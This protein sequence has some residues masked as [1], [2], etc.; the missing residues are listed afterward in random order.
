M[1]KIKYDVSKAEPGGTGLQPQPGIYLG[2]VSKV[3]DRRDQAGKNDLEVIIDVTKAMD[4][5]NKKFV[6]ARLWTYPNFGEAAD[7]KMREFTDAMG[8]KPK[9][10][11]DTDRLVGKTVGMVIVADSYQDQYKGRIGKLLHPD[12]LEEDEPDDVDED[13]DEDEDTEDEVDYSSMSL[14]DLRAAAEDEDIDHKGLSKKDLIAA[15]EGDDEDED[16]DDED[17]DEEDEPE[18]PA[19][20]K[21]KAKKA[22]PEPEEDDEDEDEDDDEDE[23]EDEEDYDE[24]SIS[25]L[26]EELE[27]RGLK[28]VGKKTSLIARLEK[29]DQSS[30]KPF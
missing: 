7:W 25:E 10:I 16:E 5:P 22:E 18:P 29:D 2:K 19:K 21:G 3:T 30:D 12:A 26:K 23:D 20:K 6:G 13:E 17:E 8:L 14:R 9:G 11:M 24:W 4:K 27:S 1:A 15:L 28:T